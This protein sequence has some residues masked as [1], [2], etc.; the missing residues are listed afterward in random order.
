MHCLCAISGDSVFLEDR[1]IDLV[2]SDA[3][4]MPAAVRFAKYVFRKGVPFL[5]QLSL[6]DESTLGPLHMCLLSL[7]CT[8]KYPSLRVMGHTSFI[9]K[10]L[11]HPVLKGTVNENFPNGLSPLDLAQQ[12]ELHHIA[13]LIERAG[14]RPGVWA[15]IPEEIELKHALALPRLRE[16]YASMKAIAED[17]EHS[18]EFIKGVFS[19]ILGG[20]IVESVVHVADDNWLVKEQVLGQRPDLGYIV[21]HV[22]PHIQARHWKRVG[23]ALGMKKSTLDELGEHFSND[24]DCHLETMSY[25]LEHG[26]SVTWKS[27][28][29]VL[30]HFETKHTVD[31]LTDKIV[32]V[33]GGDHQVSVQVLC[34]E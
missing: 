24:D 14:G 12:S 34:V 16:A 4:A 6:P 29:N 13:E 7:K 28:L 32:S 3:C 26:S 20:H 5:N 30:G 31:E 18:R 2:A 23:L 8:E 21:K 19:S 17:G 9:T 22:T 11:S 25:W 15:D 1:F 27:L 33:L 10:L